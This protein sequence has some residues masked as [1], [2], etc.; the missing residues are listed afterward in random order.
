M[1]SRNPA[2]NRPPAL[3]SPLESRS[4]GVPVPQ[5]TQTA[6]PLATSLRTLTIGSLRR[7]ATSLDGPHMLAGLNPPA[8]FMARPIMVGHRPSDG[9]RNPDSEAAKMNWV[10]C[11]IAR[12]NAE[13]PDMDRP[14][15]AFPVGS[16]PR[17]WASQSGS[18]C[19]R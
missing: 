13:P 3:A 2:L 9:L 15:T 14:T 4:D 17:F 8:Y 12:V 16:I 10:G 5:Y 1:F 6:V 18:S 19:V 11:Q 7:Q